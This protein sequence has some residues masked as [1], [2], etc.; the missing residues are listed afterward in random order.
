MPSRIMR[1]PCAIRSRSTVCLSSTNFVAIISSL[2]VF[3]R[4]KSLQSATR[5]ASST[6]FKGTFCLSRR[7]PALLKLRHFVYHAPVQMRY[8]NIDRS[9]L[10]FHAHHASLAA[11]VARLHNCEH[12]AL[13]FRQTTTSS[14]LPSHQRP[15]STDNSTPGRFFFICTGVKK[16][17]SAP[18]SSTR[19]M[20][21]PMICGDM[22]S[23][24]VSII[25]S[26]SSVAAV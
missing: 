6:T 16:Q 18:S 22:S 13:S 24:L 21:W 1:T 11:H 19:S 15:Q 3:I 4:G 23:R 2:S 8:F 12:R 10:R 25:H 9:I 5:A 17:S 20:T 14:P 7:L 26:R